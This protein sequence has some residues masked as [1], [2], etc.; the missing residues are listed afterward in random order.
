VPRPHHGVWAKEATCEDLF[1]E[2]PPGCSGG[3]V[4]RCH[5]G[6]CRC[7]VGWQGP[8]CEREAPSYCV[9]GCSGKGECRGGTCHCVEG[10]YGADCSLYS[11]EFVNQPHRLTYPDAKQKVNPGVV[12]ARRPA[13]IYVYDLPPY[14]N[15]WLYY[16]GGSHMHGHGTI[17]PTLSGQQYA[18]P[19]L[20]PAREPKAQRALRRRKEVSLSRSLA[21]G[22]CTHYT[23]SMAARA[24]VRAHATRQQLGVFLL[25]PAFLKS[26]RGGCA[27]ARSSSQ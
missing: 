3:M 25:N 18:A 21:R 13:R 23:K 2:V 11:S 12:G 15:T 9:G 5:R 17:H 22:R 27:P 7:F 20:P 6:E 24:Y 14:L 19:Y 1:R 26:Q 16:H 4:C 8:G 10:F